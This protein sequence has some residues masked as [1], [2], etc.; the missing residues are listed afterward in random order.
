MADVTA[1]V[2]GAEDSLPGL[3]TS[4]SLAGSHALVAGTGTHADGSWLPDIPA[5]AGTASAV[6]RALVERCGLSPNR[7]RVLTDP[8]DPREFLRALTGTAGRAEDLL[9]F[10]YIGH[11]LVSLGGELYLATHGTVD[12]DIGLAVEA[13]SYATVREALA[14]CRARSIMVV[15]D[16]CFSGRAGGS[17]GTA[18]ADAF[19][20]TYVRGSFLLSAASA[21][22]QALAPPGA[23][24]TAFSG[25]LLDLLREGDPAAPRY[26]TFE[27]VYRH[28]ATVMPQRGLPAPHRRAGD[29]AG[30]LVLALNP[31]APPV[32]RPRPDPDSRADAGGGSGGVRL[33]SALTCPYPGLS[34]FTEAEAR[35]FF[36]RE[37]VVADALR[38]AAGRAGN[39]PL[40]IVGRS[41]SGK[42]SLLRAGL[43]PA[44]RAGRLAVPG[45]QAWPQLV[46]TPGEHPLRTL[47]TRMAAAAGRS[48]DA[49]QARLGA[50]PG[51]LA[52]IVAAGSPTGLVL[53]VDQFEEA[54]TA[55]RDEG[56]R[57]AF[58]RA[59]CAAASGGG[60][61]GGG[62]GGARGVPVLVILG[63][64]ADFYGH[65]MN[66]P[67]LGPTLQ[68]G[69][70]PVPP[71]T[72]AELRAAIEGPAEAAGLVLDEGLTDRLLQ[73]LDA[74]AASTGADGSRD[75]GGTLPGGALPLLSYALQAT[76]GCSDGRVLTLSD[77]QATGGIWHAVTQQADQTF[78][79]LDDASREAARLLLLRMVRLGEGTDDVRRPV[80]LADLLAGRSAAER[81][82]IVAAQDALV[83]A[84]LI[85]VADDMAEITHEALLRAW[86]RLR[87]LIEEDRAELLARQR[88]ADAARAWDAEGREPGALYAGARLGQARPWLAADGKG[89]SAGSSPGSSPSRA[90]HRA[91]HAAP[92][93]AL[94]REFLAA[95]LRAER[96]RRRRGR[97]VLVAAIVVPLVLIATGVF[98]IQQRS[99]DRNAQAVQSSVALAAEADD[100]LQNNPAS[101]L[102]L[103]LT[104]YA[105][106][107]TPEARSSLYQAYTTPYDITLPGSRLAG[108]VTSVEYSPDGRTVAAASGKGGI[109][110]LWSV[111]D[112][113]HPAVL[114][115]L[116]YADR[117]SA[118]IAFS[119]DSALLAVHAQ[120]SLQLWDVRNPSH[121][122]RLSSTPLVSSVPE[123]HGQIVP[124]AF[125]PNG[126]LVATGNGD[127][128]FRL[129]NVTDP[130]HPTLDASLAPSRAAVSSV[131][132]SPRGQLLAVGSETTASRAGTARVRLW[133]ISN[134]RAPRLRQTL[135]ANAVL[136]VTFSPVG[137]LLVAGDGAA[138]SPDVWNIADLAHPSALS[139]PVNFNAPFTR[140]VGENSIAGVAFQPSGH[141]FVTTNTSGQIEIWTNSQATGL[142][143]V[144]PLP[145]PAKPYTAAYSPSGRELAVGNLNGTVQLWVMLAQL[146]PAALQLGAPGSS[147]GLHGT[148]LVTDGSQNSDGSYTTGAQLWTVN[149]LRPSL[150]A[151]LPEGWPLA[152]FLPDG[153]T[154][155]TQNTGSTA[156]RLWNATD[157]SHPEAGVTLSGLGPG[158]EPGAGVAISPNGH[159]LAV[160]GSNDKTLQVLAV[161][162]YRHVVLDATIKLSQVPNAV[163]FPTNQA[164]GAV[165]SSNQSLWDIANPR[166]PVASGSATASG[167][168]SLTYEPTAHL[169]TS[170]STNLDGLGASIS[171]LTIPGRKATVWKPGINADPDS[172]SWLGSH[173]LVAATTDDTSVQLWNV[174]YPGTLKETA[175]TV[176]LGSQ[177]TVESLVTSPNNRLVAAALDNGGDDTDPNIVEV[178]DVSGQDSLTAYAQMQGTDFQEAFSPNSQ[179]LASTLGYSALPYNVFAAGSQLTVLYPMDAGTLYQDLCAAVKGEHISSTWRRYLPT[180]T[181]YKRAC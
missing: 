135:T 123:K 39:G 10:Y 7:L 167:I 79:E 64:R 143:S 62:A 153:H 137:H 151:V 98:A 156:L 83:R 116:R 107:P 118:A 120:R 15:L 37:R 161:R 146:L 66:Y 171:H 99:S 2:T 158:I 72:T 58:I 13:L 34:P 157:P 150:A 77:Y 40:A 132:F 18:V 51:Q 70:V 30:E 142:S 148:V 180:T 61:G 26:L 28:L 152:A 95:S 113:L 170:A 6:G 166:H 22:E 71:M 29:R 110:Q 75:A 46:M 60:A 25:A 65:C 78:A 147:F 114:A 130:R 174:R 124:V 50:E 48:A 96:H 140:S 69:Q 93:S 20:L 101:S 11:G 103:S 89:F 176:P 106:A 126:Q 109:V 141:S 52:E 80:S 16:C 92:L 47:A 117:G 24:Y 111:T 129:W 105:S 4:L 36:G 134:P 5:V 149:N 122:V 55:C 76:W 81:T 100:L 33:K 168:T 121:P 138:D 73:D 14:A 162:D 136:T 128:R 94:E 144:A 8:A 163:W 1:P 63:L 90:E 67:E 112:P 41:G 74:G 17:F 49:I 169:L 44:I 84:R 139:P 91:E 3:V 155:I 88:L 115:Q 85:T 173:T 87:G 82:A 160:L 145:D 31:A 131:A 133:N 97:T 43:L 179:V 19:E 27:D 42:S 159:L 38:A 21:T 125:S 177:E 102:E 104:A 57:S 54:F 32:I 53:C 23:P 165:G 154:L 119:P 9:L 12:Q 175:A 178:W 59:L 86:P 172:L 45:A 127:G 181:Y 35:Y 108:A 68:Y 164:V 56:E